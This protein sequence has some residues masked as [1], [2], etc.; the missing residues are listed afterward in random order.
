MEEE[1]HFI[2]LL[3]HYYY[4]KSRFREP[5]VERCGAEIVSFLSH[6]TEGDPQSIQY[7]AE[8]NGFYFTTV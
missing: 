5:P 2:C 4:S 1:S 7:Y 6:K 8:L 3:W